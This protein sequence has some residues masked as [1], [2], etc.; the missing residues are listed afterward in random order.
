M[1][2][3]INVSRPRFWL[4]LF[5]P[6]LI[7]LAVSEQPL[8]YGSNARILALLLL[9]TLPANFFLYGINDLMDSDTDSLNEKKDTYERRLATSH[10]SYVRIGVGLSVLF[11]LSGFLLT[12]DVTARLSLAIFIMLGFAYSAS[13]VRLK[14]RPLLDSASNVLYVMPAIM[15]AAACGQII[16]SSAVVGGWAWSS[17]MH[18]FSAIPDISADSQAKLRTTAVVL[19]APKSLMLCALLWSVS[20]G[21]ALWFFSF[22]IVSMIAVGYA[23][24]PLFLLRSDRESLFSVYRRMPIVNAIAGFALFLSLLP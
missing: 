10:R 12:Q 11:M 22:S 6:A 3:L 5:G 23:A 4:Y 2:T 20:A 14:A 19:G 9:W 15:I 13:P 8:M 7:G 24:L 1:R 18:L 21:V 17:A 16:P